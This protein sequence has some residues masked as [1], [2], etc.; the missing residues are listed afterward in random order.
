ME[1]LGNALYVVGLTHLP[2]EKIILVG[3]FIKS[4]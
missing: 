3:D 2:L 4:F 1:I